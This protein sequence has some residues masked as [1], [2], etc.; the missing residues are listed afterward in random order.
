VFSAKR[1]GLGSLWRIS[2]SGGKSDPVVAVGHGLSQPS[3]GRRGHRLAYV[4]QIEDTNVWEVDGPRK[5]QKPHA[6][7]KLIS[8]TRRDDSPDFSP[9]GNRVIFASTR[10]GNYELWMCDK[11]G[12][13]PRQM[14]FF[15]E[16]M[17]GS[18]RWSPD[19]QW[20]AFDSQ[21]GDQTGIYVMGAEGGEARRLPTGSSADFVPSWSR[22]G[23]SIYF[24]STR[25]GSFQIWK[26]PMEGGQAT[27]V[28]KKGGY[29]S[30]ESLDGRFLYHERECSAK[31]FVNTAIWRLSLET[32]EETP[33]LAQA[34]V[35]RHWALVKEGIYFVTLGPAHPGINFFSFETGQIVSFAELEK[36]PQPPFPGLV[37]SSDARRFLYT[38]VDQSG[39]DIMLAENFR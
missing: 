6:M 39:S 20:I 37:L 4:E 10:S 33:V 21:R 25:T 27:Q 15:D 38:Q 16:G 7:H 24:C 34:G 17:T 13:N 30:I 18:P 2:I 36:A 31:S 23:R 19:G 29:N 5:R 32:G 22:D 14:T 12:S 26:V 11:D 8:S 35:E 3:L 28:T 1:G 9:D